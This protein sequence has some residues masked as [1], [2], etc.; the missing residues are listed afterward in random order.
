MTSDIFPSWNCMH[1]D[2]GA[3]FLFDKVTLSSTTTQYNLFVPVDHRRLEHVS[4]IL[5]LLFNFL[6]GGVKLRCRNERITRVGEG[7]KVFDLERINF[8]GSR[9]KHENQEIPE[10]RTKFLLISGIY[11]RFSPTRFYFLHHSKLFTNRMLSYLL[12][13]K[14]QATWAFF[15]CVILSFLMHLIVTPLQ[16][17]VKEEK[18]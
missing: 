2:Q 6:I 16:N 15:K 14:H 1:E 4:S 3:M 12:P 8:D 9:G 5:S 10:S 11:F 7:K 13:L 18:V 17:K